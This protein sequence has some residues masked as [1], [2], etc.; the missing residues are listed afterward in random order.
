MMWTNLETLIGAVARPKAFSE[1]VMPEDL[2]GE[3]V[4]PP[5][6]WPTGGGIEIR[7]LSASYE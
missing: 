4:D 3:E 2:P 1:V 6:E 5:G 7:D